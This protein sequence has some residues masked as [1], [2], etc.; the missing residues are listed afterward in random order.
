[1]KRKVLVYSVAALA[2]VAIASFTPH[3]FAA[4]QLHHGEYFSTTFDLPH[5]MPGHEQ[6]TQLELSKLSRIGS[7]YGIFYRVDQK[8]DLPTNEITTD[9]YNIKPETKEIVASFGVFLRQ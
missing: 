1:M 7:P 3:V 9:P 5:A 2:I 4:S 6:E 8:V